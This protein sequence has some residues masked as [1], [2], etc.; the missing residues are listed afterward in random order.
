MVTE[1]GAGGAGTGRTAE[2]AE[3]GLAAGEV[4]RLPR[5][6]GFAAWPPEGSAKADGKALRRLVP[7]GAHSALDLDPSA[8][9][10]SVRS[11]SPA[12]AG[13]PS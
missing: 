8:P 7:R 5:V 13:C 3:P 1:T 4:R 2:Q 10:R 6:P 9:T 11:R 12:V